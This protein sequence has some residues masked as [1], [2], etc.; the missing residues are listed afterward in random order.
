MN[1][2]PIY[3]TLTKADNY[4]CDSFEL[5]GLAFDTVVM[6]CIHFLEITIAIVTEEKDSKNRRN[7]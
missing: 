3:R 2:K 5:L 6:F 1:F 4:I 7:R